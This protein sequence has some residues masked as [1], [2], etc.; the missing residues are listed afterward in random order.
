MGRGVCGLQGNLFLQFS[1]NYKILKINI[2][3]TYFQTK[4]EKFLPY[5]KY[6]NTHSGHF[7]KDNIVTRK[8]NGGRDD[9]SKK[10]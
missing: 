4:Y 1:Y 8:M 9:K 7:Q 6:E 5:Y 2:Q 10:E 3:V